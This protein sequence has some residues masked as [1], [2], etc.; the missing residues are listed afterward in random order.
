LLT[1]DAETWA[2]TKRNKSKIKGMD[3]IF[4]E[5]LSGKQERMELEITFLGKEIQI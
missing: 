5:V 4:V 2:L 3:M 1:Y